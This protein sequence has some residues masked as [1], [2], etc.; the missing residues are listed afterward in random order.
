MDFNP[1]EHPHRRYNPLLDAW[2]LVSP[3]RTERPW[4]GQTHDPAAPDQPAYDPDCYLCP[5]NARAGGERNPAYERTF[6]FTNDFAALRPDA[7]AP[8]ENESPFGRAQPVPG[9][10][11]VLCFSPRHDRTLARMSSEELGGVI[12]LWMAQTAELGR[13]YRWVQ[14]FENRGEM[15][16]ASNPHPHGQVWALDALPSLAAREDAQQRRYHDAH[17][18]ALLLDYVDRERGGP[19]VVVENDQWLVLVP[20]WAAWPFETLVLPRQPVARLD[21]LAPRQRAGLADALKRLLVK[22]DNLF[23]APFP[24]SMGWHGA[25]FDGR[26]PRPWQLH[27]HVYPPLL[28]SASVRKFMVGFEMLAE[29]QRDLTP[30]RAAERLRAQPETHYKERLA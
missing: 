2:V 10:C 3:H 23:E 18:R 14:V 12:D 28:R 16:G 25:P 13:S 19:R 27:A 5:G 9:T 26:A 17:G 8:P 11:R 24:Y 21:G 15:M 22:Y 6:A 1:D 29:A 4:Q 20:Y 30:E 7:V